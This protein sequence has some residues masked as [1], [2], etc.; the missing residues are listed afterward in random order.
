MQGVVERRDQLGMPHAAGQAGSWRGAP[1]MANLPAGRGAGA[2]GRGQP[3]GCRRDWRTRGRAGRSGIRRLGCGRGW[4]WPMLR[5]ARAGRRAAP[6]Y[7]RP[8]GRGRRTTRRR[9]GRRCRTR[10]RT[11]PGRSCGPGC[12]GLRLPGALRVF[13]LKPGCRRGSARVTARSAALA[14]GGIAVK[15]EDGLGG[16]APEFG[17]VV[18][19]ERRAERSD[20]AGV[21]GLVERDHVHIAFRRRR[22][23]C[24]R[25]GPASRARSAA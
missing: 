6:A 11:R 20:G 23:A 3:C 21:A 1:L 4:I 2:L 7:R 9:A 13:R 12:R 25:G 16:E 14:A 8:H 5:G 19:G 10:R 24:C 18:V 17:E 22:C 15:A